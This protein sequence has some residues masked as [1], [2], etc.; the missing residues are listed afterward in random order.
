MAEAELEE[1]EAALAA[2][3]SAATSSEELSI[4]MRRCQELMDLKNECDRTLNYK[5]MDLMK[6]KVFISYH[7]SFTL[8]ISVL[9]LLLL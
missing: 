8:I 2:E 9:L 1:D 4:S 7:H 5:K 6:I 3:Q